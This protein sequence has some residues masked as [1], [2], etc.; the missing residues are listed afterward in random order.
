MLIIIV[1]MP[2]LMLMLMLMLIIIIVVVVLSHGLD[3]LETAIFITP[4]LW[5]KWYDTLWVPS[6][7]AGSNLYC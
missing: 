4:K 6:F 1:V 3:L 7:T 2:M 5:R